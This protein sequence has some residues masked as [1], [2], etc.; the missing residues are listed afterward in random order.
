MYNKTAP[1]NT[2][3][4]LRN[5]QSLITDVKTALQ[6]K[7]PLPKADLQQRLGMVYDALDMAITRINELTQAQEEAQ[8]RLREAEHQAADLMGDIDEL[9]KGDI[10]LSASDVSDIAKD[11]HD[12]AENLYFFLGA[13]VEQ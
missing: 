5:S 8:T 6:S 1:F 10:D 9:A 7:Q 11:L 2:V 13:G 3:W 4:V 12:T